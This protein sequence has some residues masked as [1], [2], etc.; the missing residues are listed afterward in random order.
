[1]SSGTV[2][3]FDPAKGFGFITPDGGGPDVFVHHSVLPHGVNSLAEGQ[4]V[5]YEAE[6]TPRGAKIVTLQLK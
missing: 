5:E 4:P 1:M 6:T 3:W 2:K